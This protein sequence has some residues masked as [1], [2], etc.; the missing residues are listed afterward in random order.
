MAFAL[1]SIVVVRDTGEI[2]SLSDGDRQDSV[3][4]L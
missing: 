2:L 4:E 3:S 1:A